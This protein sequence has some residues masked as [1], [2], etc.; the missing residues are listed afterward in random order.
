M[1][2]KA[3]KEIKALIVGAIKAKI[4]KYSP[5]TAYKP[6]IKA[7]LEEKDIVIA[8][9]CH[10]VYTTM[11]MSVYEQIGKIIADD[12][13]SYTQKGYI[14]KGE[15]DRR[16][17]DKITKIWE[18]AKVTGVVNKS[19]ELEVIRKSIV[20]SNRKLRL[21]ESVVDLFVRNKNGFEAYFDITTV[22][23]NKKEFEA[24]KRKLLLWA[25]LRF[26]TDNQVKLGTYL[27]IP[28]NP[29]YPNPYVRWNK[30]SLDP[31]E[32]IKVQ[33]DFWNFLGNS[34]KTYAELITIFEEIGKE[35]RKLVSKF[36]KKRLT[37][38]K[39]V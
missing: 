28:Y 2:E 4:L 37:S 17:A 9:F 14:L 34:D 13:G 19:K 30:S 6:F 36:I 29:Y 11:G 26:S 12:A 32:D 22:K 5:E 38:R 31:N 7:I 20:H 16:T 3:K 35:L 23:P 15:I 24:L 1:T 27:A 10:S 25:A 39:L 21:P 33:E 8:S 18:T